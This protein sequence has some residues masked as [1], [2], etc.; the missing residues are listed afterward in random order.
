MSSKRKGKSVRRRNSIQISNPQFFPT[1]KFILEISSTTMENSN[2]KTGHGRAKA[3]RLLAKANDSKTEQL[4]LIHTPDPLQNDPEVALERNNGPEKE[5]K[6]NDKDLV[7][8]LSDD[9]YSILFASKVGDPI[10]YLGVVGT[11]VL[12]G[13]VFDGMQHYKLTDRPFV[14]QPG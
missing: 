14:L 3:S 7:P 9:T 13:F 10:F 11:Y 1:H 4:S 5:Q 12:V 6:Y 8:L 2:A